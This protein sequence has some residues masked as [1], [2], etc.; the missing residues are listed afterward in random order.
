M[1]ITRRTARPFGS[2]HDEMNRLFGEL[3][4]I[5]TR[6]SFAPAMD[7]SGDDNAYFVEV[8]VPGFS[9]DNLDISF[10]DGEL[11][12][13]GEV[14]SEV[15]EGDDSGGADATVEQG[16]ADGAMT[17]ESTNTTGGTTYFRRERRM[18]SFTRTVRVPA[19]VDADGIDA[20][21]EHGVLRITLPKAEQARPRKI[22]VRQ[23]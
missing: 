20:S 23:G 21:L 7:I 3:G 19:D 11:V 18:D 9:M 22:Q 2:L 15:T 12:V 13:A 17:T 10:H 6:R 4:S 8:E 1:V 5:E 14:T 16:E